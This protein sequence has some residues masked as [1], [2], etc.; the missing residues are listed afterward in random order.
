ML[1]TSLMLA[2]IILAPSILA[3]GETNKACQLATPAELEAALGEKVTGMSG[4]ANIGSL[5]VDVCQGTTS[6]ATVLLRLAAKRDSAGSSRKDVD[7]E[8]LKA[9]GIQMDVKID[10]PITCST[11]VPT[12]KAMEAVGFNT[13]CSVVKDG[14]V[15]AIEVAVKSRA[16]MPSID[17]LKPL[18]EK[19]AGRL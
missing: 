13:T 16:D 1:K 18:A 2:L 8:K 15:A 4:A 5:G 3:A 9:M 10:G 14:H 11:A 19:M 7:L 6:K 17:K 12:S